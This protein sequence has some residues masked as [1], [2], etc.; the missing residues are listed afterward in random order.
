MKDLSAAV[1]SAVMHGTIEGW[2][3]LDRLFQNSAAH[4]VNNDPN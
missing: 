4:P 1:S 2:Q 3:R